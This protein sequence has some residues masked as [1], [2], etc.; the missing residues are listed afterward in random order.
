MKTSEFQIGELIE[1]RY[2]VLDVT[3]KGGMGTLY[4]VADAAYQNRGQ[5][6]NVLALKMVRLARAKEGHKRVE[7][8]QH[9]FQLLTQLRHP[10]LISVHDY[11]ITT[12]GQ[13]YFTMDW[14]E[15][16]DLESR[17]RRL[18]VETSTAII[19]QVCRALAYL[20][21]RGVIHGDLK[22]ANVLL[23]DDQV[24]IVDFGIALEMRTPETRSHYYSLGY[25]A[26]EIK[27]LCP[28][29]HRADLY[30]LGALW[31]ALLVGEAPI[32]MFGTERMIQFAL[33]EALEEQDMAHLGAVIV[34][35]LTSSP[36]ERYASA[37]EVIEA[38]NRATGSSYQLETRETASSYALRT[39]FV[40][41]EAEIEALEAM[42]T[43]ARSGEGKLL[44]VNGESGVGKTR[45]LE[46]FKVRSE[47]K[48]ARVVWGQCV[49]SGGSAY[50]P[51]R[52]VLRVLMRY[53]EVADESG[54]EMKRVG[55][56]LAVLLPELWE[57]DYMMGL[58]P[59]AELD[60]QAAQ[61]RLHSAIVQVLRAAA[62]LRPTMIMIED[63]QWADE[64]TLAM[65]S[66]LTHA[67]GE[68]G[69]LVCV[70]YRS[71]EIGPEYL[72][73]KLPSDRVWRIPIQTLSPQ[74]TTDL[75]CS[76][77]GLEE[78]PALLTERVQQT[79]GGNA[80]FVQELIRSLAVEGQVLRRTVEGWQIDHAALQEADMPES[81]RQVVKRRLE[82]LSEDAQQVLQWAA[83]VGMVFW[84]ECAAV[85]GQVARASV[86]AA[87][88]EAVEQDLIVER[89]ET[90][91]AGEAEYLFNNSTV[92]E[93]AYAS[94]PQEKQQA[95]HGRAATWLMAHSNAEVSEHLGLIA[96]HLERAG[97]VKQAA[98]YLHRAG[99]QAADQFANAQALNYLNRA[100]DLLSQDERTERY[101]LL[102]TRERVY[103]VQGS[104]DAQAQD[105]ETLEK[106]AQTLADKQRQAEVALRQASYSEA[107]GNYSQAIASA[108]AAIE[109]AQLDKNR[110][111]E[112][113]WRWGYA[114]WRR[115]EYQAARPQLKQ[116]LALAQ[117]VGARRIEADSLNDLGV[118]S[119]I[120]GE[121]AKAKTYMERALDIRREIG[122]RQGES[123][124]LNNL[125]IVAYYLGNQ[126][127]AL[128]ITRQSLHICREIGDRRGSALALGNLGEYAAES[129]DYATA[130]VCQE[131]SLSIRCEIGDRLGECIARSNLGIVYRSLGQYTR[132]RDYFD[133][134][135]RVSNE[136]GE[137]RMKSGCLSEMGLLFHHLGDDKAAWQYCHQ[138]QIIA[139]E[140]GIRDGLA[141]ALT[142][143]GHASVGLG[144]LEEAT[145]F[146]QQALTLW[147]ELEQHTMALDSL[148]G[149]ARVS[150]AQG[151]SL[152]AQTYVEE[153]LPH[154]ESNKLPHGSSE[155]FLVYQSCYQVLDANQDPRAWDILSSA[156][157]WLQEQAAKITDEELYYSFLENVAAHREIMREF[158]RA[159]FSRAESSRGEFT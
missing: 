140:A 78:L 121:S 95:A 159:E 136:I 9:E 21:S 4:R 77:L 81:I 133:Q 145:K 137:L 2:R 138:A 12:E 139:Q 48:G 141:S 53:V 36:D 16:Q 15:G 50:H 27:E 19:V 29:D 94:V 129:G 128:A 109:F 47:V 124:A 123:T 3:G 158:S 152:Q 42:W 142:R 122:D 155:P 117:E 108:K 114:L 73:V 28:I 89:S 79:T 125:G 120:Q 13:L 107:I 24:K 83:V 51:W 62:E 134:A 64:A 87:L 149:L 106:L 31:Y 91:F 80:F 23:V 66:V 74:V 60:P 143:L 156:H 39:R 157:R 150:L 57:R 8:F 131:Q 17:R 132:A 67:V 101:E 96:E 103:N 127:E 88:R 56:V 113:H 71:D 37:N 111:A 102:L 7:H 75:A 144:Q 76:M 45:L 100:L 41:R 93:V 18:D 98:V 154:L 70:T 104:R 105:L 44:L 1:N 63:A 25:S 38:I 35:L 52:E 11:G 33:N 147:R 115:G 119:G 65:L 43:Q 22:P 58:T 59:A 110:Q 20:H 116:A 69:M 82:Q 26:P 153:I 112:G 90:T 85:T 61:Q 130:K 46:E 55:P 72:L 151:N 84:D 99:E 14:V 40:N 97:Q 92:W 34:K 5:Q 118:I 32:F 30:S 49:E 135:L 126:D 10:N 148:A 54:L 68:I 86:W 146:Y 6:S